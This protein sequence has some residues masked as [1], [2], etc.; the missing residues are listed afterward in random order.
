MIR[1]YAFLVLVPVLLLTAACSRHEV[2]SSSTSAR[3]SEIKVTVNEGGPLVLQTS[4]A[5]FH[6]LPSGYVQGFLLKDGK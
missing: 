4:T 6:V 2:P 5:E 1:L 3:P